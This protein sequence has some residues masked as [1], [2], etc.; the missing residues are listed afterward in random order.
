MK[1]ILKGIAC[2][3]VFVMVLACV[4]TGLLMFYSKAI[5]TFCSAKGIFKSNE[6]DGNKE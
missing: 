2:G 5:G 3:T 4:Y 6:T 1:K